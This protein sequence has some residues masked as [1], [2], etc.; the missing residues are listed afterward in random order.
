LFKIATGTNITHVPYPGGGAQVMAT[1]GGHI[2][3]AVSNV[4]EV[5]PTALSGKVRALVVTTAERAEQLPDVPTLRELGYPA[6]E[7]TNWAGFVVPAA[8][9]PAVIA[10]LNAELNRAL[11]IPEVQ[12]KLKVQ[13]MYIAPT[14]PEEFTALLQSESA[15]YA[16]VVQEAGMKVE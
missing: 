4:T 5:A 14:T 16:K 11:R 2:A 13:G 8:T 1:M 12:E 3:I 9:P 7:A 6:L 15:R 10:R